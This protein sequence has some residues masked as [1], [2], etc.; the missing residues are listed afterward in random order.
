MEK[1]IGEEKAMEVGNRNVA[2]TP[3]ISSPPRRVFRLTKSMKLILKLFN[4]GEDSIP[5]PK[6]AK[7]TGLTYVSVANALQELRR[8]KLVEINGDN[9]DKRIGH[10]KITEKGKKL[11]EAIVMYERMV[12]TIMSGD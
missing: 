7:L 8:W 4:R 12:K 9:K 1:G 2:P 3:A 10:V 5:R 6:L 11:L